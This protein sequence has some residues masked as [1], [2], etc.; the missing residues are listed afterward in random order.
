VTASSARPSSGSEVPAPLDAGDLHIWFCRA[1]AVA[2]SSALAR[3]VLSRYADL[4]P[5]QWRFATGDNGKPTLVDPPRPLDFNLSDSGD[6]R[7]CAVTAG[8]AVGVDL[9]HCDP[10]RDVMKLARRFYDP[11]EVAALEACEAVDEQQSRF[12][13]YWTLKEARVKAHGIALGPALAS[14][15]FELGF[16]DRAPTG[17]P[18]RIAEV[19]PGR[20]SGAHYCLLDLAP[21]YRLATC[22]RPPAGLRPRLRLFHWHSPEGTQPFLWR[23]RAVSAPVELPA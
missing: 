19:C 22:W 14:L 2:D 1:D 17:S 9:E 5:G 20:P 11:A 16:P 12:Y 7:A 8:S 21:G 6:W 10:R 23:L 4:E 18:G 13:D 15:V 3:A